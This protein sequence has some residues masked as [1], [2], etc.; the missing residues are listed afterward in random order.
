MSSAFRRRLVLAVVAVI[1][2]TAAGPL[3][4]T[5]PTGVPDAAAADVSY[6]GRV[7]QPATPKPTAKAG[8]GPGALRV[9][10]DP[11]NLPFS[12]DR[13]EGFENRLATLVAS[14][15][16]LPL[17]YTWW[18]QR[19]GFIRSTLN[20]NLCDVIMGLP[21]SVEMA[22]TTR[23]YYRST[24]VFVTRRDRHLQLQSFDDAALRH[25]RIG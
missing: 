1:V 16:G 21:T 11:N 10:A 6:V 13:G 3:R 15:L 8:S 24:Y 23:P 2:L 25:L 17:E 12:N 18:A 4:G 19:R 14:E 22:L 5:R 9:C 7:P 20:A